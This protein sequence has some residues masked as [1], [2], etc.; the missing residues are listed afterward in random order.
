MER[1]KINLIIS[2]RA[3][4][5]LLV[6]LVAAASACASVQVKNYTLKPADGVGDYRIVEKGGLQVAV[7]FLDREGRRDFFRRNDAMGLFAVINTMPLN[8]FLV[9]LTN[10]GADHAVFDPRMSLLTDGNKTRLTPFTFVE[11]YMGM[12][13]AAGRDRMLKK[14]G[15]LI[16]ERTVSVKRAQKIEK[17]LLF[18]GTDTIGPKV[19][20]SLSEIYV[21][22]QPVEVSMDFK[23]VGGD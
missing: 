22:G 3:W 7:R 18:R 19:K 20:L 6:L 10:T 15:G 16:Y 17:L 2:V 11:L 21:N 23:A 1:S 4:L 8:I 9:R 14:L 13:G 12:R 5:L